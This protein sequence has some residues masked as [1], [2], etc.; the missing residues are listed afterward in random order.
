M[1]NQRSASLPALIATPP[2]DGR[3]STSFA[4]SFMDHPLRTLVRE[5]FLDPVL[6]K[7]QIGRSKSVEAMPL[8]T[9]D[10]TAPSPRAPVNST[11]Q[12]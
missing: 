8:K 1:C 3:L 10:S 12:S 9:A 11:N 6:R 4:T 5:L 2:N 7:L